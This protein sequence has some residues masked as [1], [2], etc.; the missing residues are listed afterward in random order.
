MRASTQ[1]DLQRRYGYFLQVLSDIGRLDPSASAGTHVTPRKR[2]RVHHCRPAAVEQCYAS[3]V[4]LQN[5]TYGRNSPR[6]EASLCWLR[7]L[8][9]DLQAEARPQHR[10]ED[11]TTDQLLEAGENLF[12]GAERASHLNPKERARLARNGL[13]VALLAVR[14]IRHKNF[15]ELTIGS[16]FRRVDD[17]WWIVLE[18]D[19]TK[20][21]RADERPVPE[22]LRSLI[23]RYL[24]TYRPVLLGTG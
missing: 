18:A 10:R 7:E 20:S 17:S 4:R 12:W 3:A 21:K 16:T 23:E 13:M 5:P 1:Q 14:P 6:P 24:A 11:V 22:Y 15:A 9:A 19:D 2:R 8:E